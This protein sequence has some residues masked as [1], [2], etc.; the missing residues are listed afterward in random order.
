MLGGSLR[1][2]HP[3]WVERRFRWFKA[4]LH[5]I[6]G[7]LSVEVSD[8]VLAPSKVTA[9]ELARDYKAQPIGVLP[10]VMGPNIQKASPLDGVPPNHEILLF[11]GRLR[12][13]KGVD[14]LLEAYKILR[15]ENQTCRLMIAG[16][17]EHRKA[18][19][20]RISNLEI[21]SEVVML[22]RCSAAQVADLLGQASALVVPSSYEGMPLVILEA[23]EAGIPVVASRVSGIPEI[24][25]DGETGWLVQPGSVEELASVLAEVLSD[26][27]EAR[28]RGSKGRQRLEVA[29]RPR[30]AAQRWLEIVGLA[31]K[32]SED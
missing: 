15:Q 5:L 23:M 9:D 32:S 14:I 27:A 4:P 7:W 11:V 18:L 10:N 31:E 2:A 25:E 26:P 16:D 28:R 1:P 21:K 19:E 8:Q 29:F 22:G 30:Q 12:I 13:R 6:L 3:S 17:G 20:R 24:V